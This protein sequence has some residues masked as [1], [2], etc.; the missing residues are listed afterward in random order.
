[1]SQSNHRQSL[2][3]RERAAILL[4]TG[5]GVGHLRTAP[6]TFGSLWGLVLAWGLHS[7]GLQPAIYVLAAV[8]IFLLGVPVCAA[9]ARYFGTHDP[10]ACVYDEI[11]AFPV[12]FALAPFTP[13]SAVAGFLLFRLFDIWKPWPVRRLERLPGGWGIAADDLMAGVYAGACLWALMTLL[14]RST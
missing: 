10:S 8:A 12:V 2:T 14:Q 5:L 4:A 1:M 3:F 13:A 9:A 6:G 11:A 7:A